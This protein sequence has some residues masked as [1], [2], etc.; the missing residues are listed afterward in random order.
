MEAECNS[1]GRTDLEDCPT[2]LTSKP[3]RLFSAEAPRIRKGPRLQA[4][5]LRPRNQCGNAHTAETRAAFK[6]K[7]FSDRGGGGAV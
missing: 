5:G 7:L 4:A 1:A 3:E 2:W 6:K